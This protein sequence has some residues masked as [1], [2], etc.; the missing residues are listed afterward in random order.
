MSLLGNDGTVARLME[1]P[2]AH[3]TMPETTKLV[4]VLGL[5]PSPAAP[6]G[7]WLAETTTTM[8][9]AARTRLFGAIILLGCCSIAS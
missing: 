8:S 3:G 5:A 1:F 9:R 4:L 2:V 6:R 7:S